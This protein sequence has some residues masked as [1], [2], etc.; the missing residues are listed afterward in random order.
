MLLVTT[1][2]WNIFP[3]WVRRNEKSKIIL[4]DGRNK[5]FTLY[6]GGAVHK[7]THWGSSRLVVSICAM[8]DDLNVREVQ[9]RFLW[10]WLEGSGIL[11]NG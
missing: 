10:M 9:R 7:R 2:K 4:P 1:K 3:F 11:M 6:L 5:I 8:K